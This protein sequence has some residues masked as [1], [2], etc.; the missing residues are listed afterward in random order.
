MTCTEVGTG[1]P[2]CC[3]ADCEVLGVGYPKWALMDPND[4]LLGGLVVTHTSEW[5]AHAPPAI[6][7]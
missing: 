6:P 1:A 5:C 2:V 3:T 4:P 7:A